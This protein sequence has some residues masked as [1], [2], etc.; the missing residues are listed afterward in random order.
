MISERVISVHFPKA[1]G[2]SLRSQFE[3]HVGSGLFL[4]YNHD[5]LGDN[6][7]EP[8]EAFSESIKIVHGHFRADRYDKEASAVRLTILRHP[9]DNLISIYFFWLGLPS[10]GNP[11]HDRF[12]AERP[13]IETFARYSGMHDL[14][15]H[16]YFGGY[17]MNRMNFVG[18][19]E[20]RTTDIPRL[21]LLLDLPL[22][23]EVHENRTPSADDVIRAELMQDH[24]T[25]GKIADG[26]AAD[27]AFY[28]V[29]YSRWSVRGGA[30]K[31]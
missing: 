5:P 30:P 16:S 18:F 19:H 24:T 20:D 29:Q 3:K 26:L 9:V 21:G 11:L 17:D 10:I 15:S 13:S 7:Y 8:P 28:D 2:T 22:S 25:L 14:M 6:V 23:A 12:L 4:D 31:S 1:A 27:L